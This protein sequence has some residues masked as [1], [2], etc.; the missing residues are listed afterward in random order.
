[1]APSQLLGNRKDSGEAPIVRKSHDEFSGLAQFL[2][3][4]IRAGR[5]SVLR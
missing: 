2:S 3:G 4:R 5:R 1:M